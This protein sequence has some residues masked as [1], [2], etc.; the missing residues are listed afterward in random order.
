M[1]IVF[2]CECVCG[3]LRLFLQSGGL[4]EWYSVVMVSSRTPHKGDR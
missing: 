3:N 1:F 2:V 4:L